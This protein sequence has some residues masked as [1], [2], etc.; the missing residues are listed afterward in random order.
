MRSRFTVSTLFTVAALGLCQSA[1]AQQTVARVYVIK[2]QPG[3]EMLF[4]QALAA[5]SEWR[6]QNKDPWSWGVAQVVAGDDLGLWYIRSA[7]HPWADLDTYDA[8]FAQ[9][10]LEHW[11]TNVAPHVANVSS[12]VTTTDTTNLHW[13][14]DQSA[15]RFVTLVDFYLRPGQQEEFFAVVNKFHKALMQQKAPTY[16]SF[17]MS[18]AG[19]P[20]DLIRL[21]LPYKSWA[22]MAPRDTPMAAIIAKAYGADEAKALNDRFNNILRRVQTTVLMMRPD[23]SVGMGM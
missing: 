22:D 14:V 7:G 18:V 9:K 4:E 11:M 2:P 17:N 20:G 1:A 16:Y 3:H 12:Y 21:A 10:A 8:G 6:R 15:I 23:L 5:H 13:P 19:G